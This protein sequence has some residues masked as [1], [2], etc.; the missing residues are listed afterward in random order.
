M[1]LTTLLDRNAAFAA[2]DARAKAPAVPFIP[3]ELAFVVTCLDPR[4]DQADFLELELGDA[5]VLRCLGGRITPAVLEQIA[6]I[7]YLLENKTPAGP[8]FELAVVHHTDCGTGFLADEAL[9]HD[10]AATAGYDEEQWAQ[11]PGLAP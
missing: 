10:F 8:Y 1:S 11:L 2:T 9:R 5:I 6:Y 7:S 3:N 4:T